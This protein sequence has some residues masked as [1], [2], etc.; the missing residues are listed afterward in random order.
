MNQVMS[1]MKREIGAREKREMDARIARKMLLELCIIKT[2]DNSLNGNDTQGSDDP[3]MVD[4][5]N[6]EPEDKD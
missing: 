4:L 6:E 1:N 2:T 5:V 3:I